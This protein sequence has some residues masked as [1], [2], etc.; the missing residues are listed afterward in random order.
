MMFE[1]LLAESLVS[2]KLPT[3]GSEF[4]DTGTTEGRVITQRNHSSAPGRRENNSKAWGDCRPKRPG[5]LVLGAQGLEAFKNK[6]I[7]VSQYMFSSGN[8]T[9][10]V[11]V[12][13]NA[14]EREQSGSYK[15]RQVPGNTATHSGFLV[16]PRGSLS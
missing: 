15:A 5:I 1:K 14:F 2:H 11:K 3:H 7:S 10:S 16:S 12:M 13:L 8:D 6:A 4:Q 9:K